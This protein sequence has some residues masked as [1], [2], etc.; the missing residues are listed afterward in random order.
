M[1]GRLATM[2]RLI[3]AVPQLETPVAVGADSRPLGSFA[4]IAALA[5]KGYESSSAISETPKA[6]FIAD[7]SAKREHD[8]Y[9]S[10]VHDRSSA[11]REL[12]WFK[13][14]DLLNA[15]RQ[16]F[17]VITSL[18]EE[19]AEAGVANLRTLFGSLDM[20]DC[21]ACA[22]ITSPAAY[23]ADVLNF[24]GT[25]VATAGTSPYEVLIGRRPD[26]PHILLNCDNTNRALPYIDLVNELL[27]DEVLRQAGAKPVW[28][29]HKKVKLVG[30]TSAV[31]DDAASNRAVSA[32]PAKKQ[33]IEVLNKALRGYGFEAETEVRS[34]RV[35]SR[36]ELA[37]TCS[38]AAGWSNRVSRNH[39]RPSRSTTSAARRSVPTPSLPRI[40][41]FATRERLGC[42]RARS[43][44]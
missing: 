27:E 7:V 1:K 30:L 42:W 43:F 8:A 39:P 33:L 19:P 10:E 25:D 9:W 3:R 35:A 17:P 31:L 12:A 20:C 44:R 34:L 32:I 36:R 14:I 13:G 16:P 15:Y 26:I 5:D 2:S 11:V 4:T 40:R 38:G 21:E 29:P 23:L 28:S 6:A 22:S 41:R 37:G 18:Q 24:L